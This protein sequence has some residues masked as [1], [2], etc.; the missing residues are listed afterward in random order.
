M[1]ASREHVPILVFGP[2]CAEG[3]DLGVRQTFSDVGATLADAFGV[4]P[5]RS[6]GRD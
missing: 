5:P 4:A 1:T 3:R 6:M 2:A